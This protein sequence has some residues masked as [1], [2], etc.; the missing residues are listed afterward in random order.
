M[1]LQNTP[2]SRSERKYKMT[3]AGQLFKH[4]GLQMYSGAVPAISELISNAYDAMARNV[5]IEL[6]THT[7]ITSSDEIVVRD[8][9]H[10]M[11]FD[12]CNS[13]YLS[14]G[15]D[16]R[17]KHDEWTKEYRDLSS[18]KVQGRKGIGKLA[19]FGI[20]N[21]IDV[22][23]IKSEKIAHFRMDYDELT[24]SSNFADTEGY[25][26]KSLPDDGRQTDDPAG[27]TV[28]LSRLKLSRSINEEQFKKSIA[29]RLLVIDESFTVHVN[30]TQVSR[31]E[32]PFQFRFPKSAGAWQTDELSNGQQFHWWAG[33]CDGTIPD[34]EQRGFVVY[35]RGKLAQTPWFFDLSG[36]VWGQ[37][38]MQ[39]FT[40]E[41]KADFLDDSVDLIAT[42]RGTVR[43]EDPAAVPLKDWG[44]KKIRELLETWSKKRREA[45]LKSPKVMEFLSQAE[46]LP[47]R[48]RQI[49]AKVVDRICAIPQ[50]DKDQ[51]GRDIADELVEFAYNA[52]TNLS[53]LDAIR[54]L[55]AAS[56]NEMDRFSEVLS[57]WDIIEL[58][59]TAHLVKGRVEIIRKFKQMIDDR[60]PEKPDMQNYVRDHP[61]LID[62]K[63]TALAHEKT[64]DRLIAD[65]FGIKTSD[66]NEG[67]RRLDF[68]CLG[69]RYKTAH[70]VETKRPGEIVGRQEC[71][72]LRDYVLFLQRKL[73]HEADEENRRTTVRGLLIADRIRPEDEIHAQTHQ[74]AGTFDIRTWDNLLT[75]TET[76]HEEFLNVVRTRVPSDDPRMRSLLDESIN[77]PIDS[78]ED[79]G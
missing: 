67:R 32:I 22:R 70:V 52:L 11:S 40:G 21:L 5:W 55:N 6:P 57:D 20:A 75:T 33:F 12:E 44:R 63:W 78:N 51:E 38:G 1:K 79:Q 24:R 18:R 46:K 13:R 42:D 71:D 74:Q 36:G 9:G 19:G 25:A 39:Y 37:H 2:T 60:V 69:D 43:W 56:P 54:R 3:V 34:E 47:E 4:L 28:R 50:L 41:I 14:V 66:G 48:E 16:R 7:S 65:E 35:V 26:P 29:R 17:I 72:Q 23:T 77:A 15:R 49:F 62:P 68:F 31:Q 64:L 61:W 45:K 8:D 73:Q 30:D 53:F 76:L 58:V 59:N 10:G 27:T